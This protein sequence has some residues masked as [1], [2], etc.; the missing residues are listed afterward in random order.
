MKITI[1]NLGPIK[2]CVIEPSNFT[3]LMGEQASGKSTI[4]KCVYFFSTI[5][6]DICDA[7]LKKEIL[8]PKE[9]KEILINKFVRLFGLIISINPCMDLKC[10]FSYGISIHI[11]LSSS[12]E[13]NNKQEI[14]REDLKVKNQKN[15]NL[16][17]SLNRNDLLKNTINIKPLIDDTNIKSFIDYVL[18]TYKPTLKISL[19]N[20]IIQKLKQLDSIKNKVILQKQLDDFFHNDYK[21]IF[22]P[23]GR[24]LA[25]QLSKQLNYLY[26]SMGDELKNSLDY[27]TQKFI[28]TILYCR[29]SLQNGIEGLQSLS[30]SQWKDDIAN[31]L[32][33]HYVCTADGEERLYLSKDTNS[34]NFVSFHLASSGQQEVA[35]ILNIVAYYLDAYKRTGIKTMFIIEEPETH[36]YPAAQ[37][38]LMELLAFV[39]NHSQG[40]FIT[41]HS[42]YVLGSL[43]NLLY[44]GSRPAKFKKKIAEIIPEAYQLK[45]I[46]AFYLKDGGI[47]AAIDDETKPLIQNGLIDDASHELNDEFDGMINIQFKS[48]EDHALS[49]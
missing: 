2:D 10:V 18:K 39:A 48:E 30:S 15:K 41:T 26:A 24:S 6:D 44:A 1:H 43:N 22:I 38:K 35:W 21:T 13:T 28:E 33:G 29:I 16:V 20:K 12:I 42:P 7:Y 23:A 14:E 34:N 4:A 3:V 46:D 17:V 11:S 19:S 27:T 40:M 25:A 49:K 32:K 37:K 45:H 31:L 36:L 8:G 5:K 47:E 9:L